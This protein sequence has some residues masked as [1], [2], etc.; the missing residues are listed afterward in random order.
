MTVSVRPFAVGR[1]IENVLPTSYIVDAGGGVVDG[2][3]GSNRP[4]KSVEGWL[5]PGGYGNV[6]GILSA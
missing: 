4:K 3:G 5:G 6:T 2:S 1:V